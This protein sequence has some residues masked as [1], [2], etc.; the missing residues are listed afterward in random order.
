[1]NKSIFSHNSLK[2][3]TKLYNGSKKNAIHL[4]FKVPVLCAKIPKHFKPGSTCFNGFLSSKEKGLAASLH[5][6]M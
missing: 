6:V 3:T 2:E 1:M 4:R 5:F